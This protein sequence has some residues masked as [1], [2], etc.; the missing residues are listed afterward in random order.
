[1]QRYKPTPRGI[2]THFWDR[3]EAQV[4]A[5]L[6]AHILDWYKRRE[7]DAGYTMLQ[8]VPRSV[9]GKEDKQRPADSKTDKLQPYQE[10]AMYHRAHVA[11]VNAEMARPF[12]GDLADGSRCGG[13]DVQKMRIAGLARTIQAQRY[14]HSCTL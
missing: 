3:T 13:F 5:A 2:Y 1:M 12:V 8:A 6:H 10:D 14:T 7:Q 11:R 9:S 4:R